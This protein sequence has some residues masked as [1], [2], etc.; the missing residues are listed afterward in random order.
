M[1]KQDFLI[2][3]RKQAEAGDTV[4]ANPQK[5]GGGLAC[6]RRTS[7]SPRPAA[8]ILRLCVG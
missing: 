3:N 6:A 8:E 2:L 7:R 4:F 5:F 1:L